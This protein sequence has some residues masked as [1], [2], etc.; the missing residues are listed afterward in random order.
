MN[1]F[2]KLIFVSSSGTL[3]TIFYFII[4]LQIRQ[5]IRRSSK[6]QS[7][8]NNRGYGQCTLKSADHHHH[9]LRHNSC[10]TTLALGDAGGIPAL[11]IRFDI[12]LSENS[13][14]FGKKEMSNLH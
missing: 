12:N 6:E 1:P 2:E 10:K 4:K 7:P 9:H 14:L 13:L 11:L 5:D 3:F 8:L